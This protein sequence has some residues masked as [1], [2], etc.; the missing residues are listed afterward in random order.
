MTPTTHD[1]NIFVKLTIVT[2]LSLRER[3]AVANLSFSF[4]PLGGSDPP[5]AQTKGF[6]NRKSSSYFQVDPSLYGTVREFSRTFSQLRRTALFTR[7]DPINRCILQLLVDISPTIEQCISV[8]APARVS[9]KPLADQVHPAVQKQ[10][11]DK[12]PFLKKPVVLHLTKTL[13]LLHAVV[14]P[15]FFLQRSIS[16]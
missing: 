7:I 13:L 4:E 6:V 11:R 5:I 14:P 8:I 2:H 3:I 9:F 1:T 15:C 16:P 10:R 12:L